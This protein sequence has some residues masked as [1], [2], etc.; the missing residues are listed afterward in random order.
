MYLCAVINALF[1]SIVEIIIFVVA[2]NKGKDVGSQECFTE[3]VK[4]T[5]AGTVKL[6][7]SSHLRAGKNWLLNK[8]DL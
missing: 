2:L 6:D 7:L 5:L 8:G 4:A 1:G 3:I